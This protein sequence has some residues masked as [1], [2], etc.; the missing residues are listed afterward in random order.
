MVVSRDT[1]HSALGVIHRNI[2]GM[3]VVCSKR[4]LTLV[5]F[6]ERIHGGFGSRKAKGIAPHH[7]DARMIQF[8]RSHL[9]VNS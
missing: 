1:P 6:I 4:Y 7:V 8:Q 5:E 9:F 3:K 2:E